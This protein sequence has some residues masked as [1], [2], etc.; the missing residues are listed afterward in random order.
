MQGSTCI[1][2]VHTGMI[3]LL[4]SVLLNILRT[5]RHII[6][7]YVIR[8]TGRAHNDMRGRKSIVCCG[9]MHG[10]RRHRDDFGFGGVLHAKQN[11]KRLSATG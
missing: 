6:I 11:K 5:T 4:Y 1:R 7:I 9:I 10:G 2:G 8:Y 3:L